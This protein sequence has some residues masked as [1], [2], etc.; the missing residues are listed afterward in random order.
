[1]NSGPLCRCSARAR[2][3]GMRHGVY[4]AEQSFR[5]ITVSPPT[6]FLI[7]SPTIIAHDEHEFLFSGFSMFSHYK[8][9][10]LPTCKVIRFNIEYTILYVQEPAPENFTKLAEYHKMDHYYWQKFVDRIKG[11]FW[12]LSMC[13]VMKYLVN[14]S[15][16]LIPP[17]KL[18]EYHKM[19][20]YYWQKFVD[21][22]KGMFYVLSMCEVM[23]Y[24][25]NKSGLLIPPEKLD[26]YHKMDHYYWLKFVDRI[27]GMFYVLSMC[28]V[29]KYLVNESGLLIPPEKLAEYHKMDHYYWQKFVDRI[30]GMFYVL[31]MCV[32]MKCLVNKS[33][34][35]IPPE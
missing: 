1:M 10:K 7:K 12:V 28:E 5:N 31:S 2:R 27:K 25:V 19:D 13:E 22:I 3:F 8:L 23:K 33:G 32:V 15:G 14:E 35:L 16:L 11:M 21:R 4:A 6:N 26:Q 30:K 24:L 34:L 29:M 20:H 17:E 9:A 18:A